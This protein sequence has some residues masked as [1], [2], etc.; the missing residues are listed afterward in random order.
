MRNKIKQYITVDTIPYV[1]ILALFAIIHIKIN[2]NFG[3][4]VV[5]RNT[6]VNIFGDFVQNYHIWGSP[7][8]LFLLNRLFP[9]IPQIYFKV[10]D[11]LVIILAQY[12]ISKIVD[13]KKAKYTKFIIVLL[14]V[15][16]P[17]KQMSTAGWIATTTTYSFP[18]AF[19]LYS[20]VYLKLI[21]DNKEINK[22]N[23]ILFWISLVLGAGGLQFSL[24]IFGI[25]AI[26]NIKF[27]MKRKIYKFS[28]LQNITALLFVIYHI[29]IT[30][31][32][33]QEY[34][35]NYYMVP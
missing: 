32:C 6:D 25:Y 11:I 26:F 21:V 13:D 23:Y 27:I 33:K 20:F 1:L 34:S 16:Y 4:D 22:L 30:R 10:C 31:E 19:G 24:I 12:S 3:D 28:I 15:L 2:T 14:I 8:L 9:R 18:L 29:N 7:G 17:F 5:L 35:G